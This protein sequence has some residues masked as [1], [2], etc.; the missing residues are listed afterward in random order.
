MWILNPMQRYGGFHYQT[1]L[2]QDF[3][4]S[5]CD[6]EAN[7][8]QTYGIALSPVAR[9]WQSLPHFVGPII[10]NFILNIKRGSQPNTASPNYSE[11]NRPVPKA[12]SGRNGRQKCRERS[13]YH[14][15]CNLNNTLF[16]FLFKSFLILYSCLSL[17]SGTDVKSQATFSSGPDHS[18][19]PRRNAPAEA[20]AS[21]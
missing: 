9:K 15:H 18:E 20:P 10:D 4:W 6:K 17:G 14:L 12:R 13:Y 7:L 1:I 3:V 8:R 5:L 21:N 16:H 19:R 2:L 11:C